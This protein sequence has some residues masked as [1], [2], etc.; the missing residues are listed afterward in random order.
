MVR[1][2]TGTLARSLRFQMATGYRECEMLNQFSRTTALLSLAS[3]ASALLLV[4]GAVPRA[5][6]V[7]VALAFAWATGVADGHAHLRRRNPDAFA[8]GT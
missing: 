5:L 2:R 6:L 1:E 4:E 8:G 7:A 3:T